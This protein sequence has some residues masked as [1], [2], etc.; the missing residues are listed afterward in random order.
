M[1][2]LGSTSSDTTTSVTR[3]ILL[4][5][6]PPK[7]RR[8]RTLPHNSLLATIFLR[9]CA[10]VLAAIAPIT[11]AQQ[12]DSGFHP[13]FDGTVNAVMMQPDGKVLVGG[14]FLNVNNTPCRYICRLN[15]DGSIDSQFAVSP[16]ADGGV[17]TLALQPDGKVLVGGVF[18]N[19]GGQPRKRF[20]RLSGS[21]ALDAT[22][23]DPLVDAPFGNI[24]YTAVVQ[25][26]GS[27]LIGGQFSSVGGVAHH[28]VA[29]LKGNGSVDPAFSDANVSGY[30]VS[31]VAG[32]DVQ[33]DNRV[34]IVGAFN[35]VGGQTRTRV[36]R[37]FADG[38]LD[39]SLIDVAPNSNVTALALQADGKFLVGGNF[40]SI[41]QSGPAYLA[42]LNTDGS[43]DVAF[44]PAAGGPVGAL[45]MQPDGR[46]LA[47]GSFVS[48]GGQP[49][50]FLA[51]L[52]SSG[53]LDTSF[54]AGIEATAN[55]DVTSVALRSDGNIFI[56][57]DFTSIAGIS[58]IR[59]AELFAAGTSNNGA[60][61]L[62]PSGAFA[63]EVYALATQPDGKVLVGG[64]FTMIGGVPRHNLAR[65][66]PDGSVDPTFSDPN[67]IGGLFNS[68][69]QVAT[70]SIQDD[71]KI[72]IS[73]QFNSIANSTR[74]YLARLNTDGT[75]DSFDPEPD[76]PVAAVA[77][78]PG[79]QVL[80]YGNFATL[81]NMACHYV[82]RLNANGSLDSSFQDPTLAG[83]QQPY[84]LAVQSDGKILIG[85]SFTSVDGMSMRKVARLN[86]NGGLD[87]GFADPA[88]NCVADGLVVQ[89]DGRIVVTGCFD[90]A[91]G[92][93][94]L[95]FARLNPG[96]TVDDTF[97]VPLADVGNYVFNLALQAD[98]R[99]LVG[100]NFTMFGT[101]TRHRLARLNTDGSLDQSFGDV[102]A[103]Q[104]VAALAQAPDGS[105][106]LG[107]RFTTIAGNARVAYAH[108]AP[109]EVTAQTLSIGPSGR[110]VVWSR[111]GVAPELARA[112]Q[113]LISTD[114]TTFS[115][116][117]TM[118]RVAGG[119]QFDGLD[120]PIGTS[121]Y[122]AT[123]APLSSGFANASTG[124]A[125]TLRQGYVRDSIFADGF[126]H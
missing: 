126:D 16:V 77:A 91:G 23:G 5:V 97:N 28:A 32:I 98:G 104:Y 35:S 46:V 67:I 82:C 57:G 72:L 56:G 102:N 24:V 107:G 47:G 74:H 120:A 90:T 38:T 55:A 22:F 122:L 118:T 59:I 21:G 31:F 64:Y 14:Q 3:T 100:G 39:P 89:P 13:S 18:G 15:P 12:L 76:G 37:L 58:H 43:L 68:G 6:A 103:D 17:Y 99:V 119:W 63:P 8:A 112:P 45:V 105:V 87:P 83:G 125:G 71:G 7:A 2:W 60:P 70:I 94:H 88:M 48:M 44:N 36:A 54:N 27:I 108:L 65:L 50:N 121:F 1:Q 52:E 66:N 113:L 81:A 80:V 78:L 42:R 111:S 75:L 79:G 11:I 95:L 33:P 114:N 40:T 92:S 86:V 123:R 29:R 73:G 19:I 124:L 115:A 116:V 20:A 96:G 109:T 4:A 30:L 53:S 62:A 85:G 93:S 26:D 69:G 41:A 61:D 106:L 9:A 117:G 10:P 84:A 101:T 51:R 110:S 49:R 34:V 25:G